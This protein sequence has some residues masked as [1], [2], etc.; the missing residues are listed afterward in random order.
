MGR[1]KAGDW[2]R[3]MVLTLSLLAL[4]SATG[5]SQSLSVCDEAKLE[6]DTWFTA[7]VDVESLTWERLADYSTGERR[8]I[9]HRLSVSARSN[10]WREHLWRMAMD[11][12]FDSTQRSFIESV[13]TNYDKYVDN[14]D[15]SKPVVEEALQ[16]F[17]QEKVRSVFW[18]LGPATTVSGST[19]ADVPDSF[20]SCDCW[21]DPFWGWY[22]PIDMSCTG[23]GC[24]GFPFGCGF[25]GLFPCDSQC[26]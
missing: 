14:P 20:R 5:S 10:L 17:D 9:F 21:S 6:A 18:Q 1:A 2:L 15:M 13:R 19:P 12:Q 8:A 3:R 7:N 4:I 24:S 26:E 22:C 25:L 23:G 16:L 11:D